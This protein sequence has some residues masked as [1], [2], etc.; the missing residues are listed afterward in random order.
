MTP[1]RP[2]LWALLLLALGFIICGGGMLAALA[3][4]LAQAWSAGR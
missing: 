2:S 4:C 3:W 1:Q